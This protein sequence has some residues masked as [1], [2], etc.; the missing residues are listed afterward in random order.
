MP[1]YSPLIRSV[2]VGFFL[3]MVKAPCIEIGTSWWGVRRPMS[4][5]YKA[6]MGDYA[7]PAAYL[8][9]TARCWG[10]R[11]RVSG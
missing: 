3:R 1:A 2:N 7:S 5:I 6:A 11:V 10:R 4:R 9:R 8:P